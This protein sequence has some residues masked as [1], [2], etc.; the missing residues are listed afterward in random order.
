MLFG[1]CYYPEHWEQERWETD[2]RLMKEAGFNVVRLAEFAWIRM[3]PEE[4]RYEFGWLDQAIALFGDYDIQVILGTPTAGPPKWLMDKHPDMYQQ[5]YQGHVRGFGTRRHYCANSP[6]YHGYTSKIVTRMAEQYREHP[7]VIGWQIDNELGAI[8]TAR[9]YCG[10]CREAFITWLQQRYGSL[11]Q[12]NEEW[13]TIFS[14]QSY[15]GW[16]QLHLPTYSVHQGHNPGLALDFRRF[17]SDSV[18]KYQQLQLD[19][20]RSLCPST[21]PIT[22]NMMGSFNDLDYYD[23]AAPLDIVSLDIYPIMKRVPE[24]RA[25]R[26]G[27]NHD[28]MRGLKGQ[29]FWVLEHQSGAPCTYAM[30]STPRPGELRRWTY[31]SIARGADAIVYFRWRTLTYALEEFWHGILQHHGQPGRR[32]EEVKQ[33]GRELAAISPLLAGTT[34]KAKVAML[35]CFHNE[36]A[37]ELQPHGSGYEYKEH[38]AQYYRYFHERNILVDIISPDASFDG[39]ELLIIPNFMMAREEA[40]KRIHAFAERGGTIVMD[41]RAGA[42]EWNNR[43]LPQR[44]PGLYADLLGI[45]IDDYGI[46]EEDISIGLLEPE[47]EAAA[48]SD[49]ATYPGEAATWYD[50]IELEG[51]EPLLLFAN[52]YF[53]GQPAVTRNRYGLGTAYYLGTE[54]D[55]ASLHRLFHSICKDLNLEPVL[56]GLPS[57]VEAICRMREEGER[58]SEVIFVINHSRVDAAF[59]L[60]RI[61]ADAMTGTELSG[62]VVMAPNGVLVLGSTG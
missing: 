7:N 46:I 1:A 14:S 47:A 5:D 54:L 34:V 12:L 39:Y 13:G 24:E 41:F 61:Y 58:S 44:L 29:N 26:T 32:F 3:E 60:D 40:T 55:S 15:T 8:D 11:E 2:A 4:G 9:C 16:E 23:L 30:S 45:S 18:V 43:M 48:A 38:Q 31:Q 49:S 28:T 59:T 56:P 53:A 51:A 42:K 35:K 52:D 19:I 21:Q 6:N 33:V 27:L 50:V 57:G 10:N 20:L 17:S 25:F 36:W 62:E 22:T 37:F